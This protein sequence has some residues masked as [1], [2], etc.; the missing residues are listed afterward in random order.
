MTNKLVLVVSLV[1]MCVAIS[2]KDNEYRHKK[3][4]MHRIIKTQKNFKSFVT[5]KKYSNRIKKH[6]II[7]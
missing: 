6:I 1:F 3:S 4:V 2:A 5:R 7:N